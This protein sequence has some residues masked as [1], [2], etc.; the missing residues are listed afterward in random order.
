MLSIQVGPNRRMQRIARDL[1]DMIQVIQ[2]FFQVAMSPL[3]CGLPPHPTR[4]YHPGIQCAPNDSP[5]PYEG[6][7]HFIAELTVMIHQGPAI[8]V[9]GPDGAAEYVHRIPKSIVAEM[10]G[11]QDDI[12]PFYFP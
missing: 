1:T 6:L 12:Q 5:F 9:T 10:G 8:I 7:Y 2:H 4:H 3:R 11:V